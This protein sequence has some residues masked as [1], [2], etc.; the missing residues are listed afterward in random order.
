MKFSVAYFKERVDGADRVHVYTVSEK[1]HRH[2]RLLTPR[3]QEL[4][5]TDSDLLHAEVV[6]RA[7]G[8]IPPETQNP[9][10]EFLGSMEDLDHDEAGQLILTRGEEQATRAREEEERKADQRKANS[11][12]RQR[13]REE[14]PTET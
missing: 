2:D 9:P 1:G 14:A 11:S 6:S 10:V 8:T 7:Y 3:E 5:A 12:A 4:L 13:E